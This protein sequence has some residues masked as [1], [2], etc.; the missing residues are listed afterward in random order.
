MPSKKKSGKSLSPKRQKFIQ[1]YAVTHNGTQ[2][3]LKAGYSPKT[4]YSAA[5]E[6]LKIPEVQA[7]L[8]RLEKA[9]AARNNV[10]VDEIINR[11]Y[12]E[13]LAGDPNEPSSARIKA[14]ELI[15]KHLGMWRDRSNEPDNTTVQSILNLL[16][17]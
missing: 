16:R 12:N 8:A 7:E 2:A 6:I 9:A 1:E 5:H 14:L 10:T 3:A 11:L 13:A 15:G 17:K 4:A